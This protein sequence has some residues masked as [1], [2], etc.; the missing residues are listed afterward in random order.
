VLRSLKL[1]ISL[2]LQCSF[3]LSDISCNRQRSSPP[4]IREICP[5]CEVRTDRLMANEI[6]DVG[7]SET[8]DSLACLC[9]VVKVEMT[10]KQWP[11]SRR[12][13]AGI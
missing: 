12:F 4:C 6:R 2:L 8:L 10:G 1:F 9:E 3:D 5:V 13:M 7:A 11:K